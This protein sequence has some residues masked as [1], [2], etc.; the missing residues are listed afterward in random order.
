MALKKSSPCSSKL[1]SNLIKKAF[2]LSNGCNTMYGTIANIRGRVLEDVLGFED[3]FENTFWRPWPWPWSLKSSK[4]ALSS[5]RGQ[6][7]F[8][9][10]WNFVEKHLKPRGNFATTFFVFVYWSIGVAKRGQGARPTQ[11]K[12]HQWQKCDKIVY[13]FFSF[14]FFLAFFAYISN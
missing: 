7:Y 13:C 8:L 1:L 10:S 11:S 4:I 6:H 5:A 2:V 9:N 14:T 12:F 3:V